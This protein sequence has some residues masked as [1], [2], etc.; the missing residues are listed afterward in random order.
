MKIKGWH[1]LREGSRLPSYC[2]SCGHQTIH[3]VTGIRR[4]GSAEIVRLECTVCM[5]RLGKKIPFFKSK[6]PSA[7][8]G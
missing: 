2:E 3:I 5:E 1:N 4:D 8:Y 7:T 6:K